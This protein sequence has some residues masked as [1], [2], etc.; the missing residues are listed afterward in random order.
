MLIFL[1]WEWTARRGNGKQLFR[2][3]DAMNAQ[4]KQKIAEIAEQC[5]VPGWDGYGANAIT[6]EAV[7]QA[8]AF[9]D[10]IPP[11]L[12]APDPGVE[13]DGAV[14]FE[15]YWTL[16]Q[17]LSVSVDGSGAVHYAA[18]LGTESICG[19]ETFRDRMPEKLVDLITRIAESSGQGFVA[20]YYIG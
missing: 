19:T 16:R 20:E 3:D 17:T 15:W 2:T 12:P 8:R 7:A 6:P 4:L 11:H 1:T 14:T 10:A 5:A 13:P 18:L 9:A